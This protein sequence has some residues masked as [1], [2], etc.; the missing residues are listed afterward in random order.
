MINHKCSQKVGITHFF[1]KKKK[2]TNKYHTRN[3]P[4]YCTPNYFQM[5]KN[6]IIKI[7]NDFIKAEDL[8]L[9]VLTNQIFSHHTHEMNKYDNLEIIQHLTTIFFNNKIQLLHNHTNQLKCIPKFHCH[10]I[11]INTK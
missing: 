11:Y 4:H 7:S 2:N 1:N 9:T 8:F 10:I 6:I 3:Q 5:T